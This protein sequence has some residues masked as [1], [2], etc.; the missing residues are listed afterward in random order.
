LVAELK[1]FKKALR[2]VL[3]AFH[4]KRGRSSSKVKRYQKE[5]NRGEFISKVEEILCL[6]QEPDLSLKEKLQS[7]LSFCFYNFKLC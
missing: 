3:K 2:K 1:T 5:W 6:I 7:A 4:N